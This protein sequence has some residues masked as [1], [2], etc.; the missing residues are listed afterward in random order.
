MNEFMASVRV[1]SSQE[2]A[3]T[4][5][6]PD[7]NALGIPTADQQRMAT[8]QRVQEWNA[9]MESMRANESSLALSQEATGTHNSTDRN[10]LGIPT[11]DRQRIATQQRVR[12]LNEFM[13]FVRTNESSR[14]PRQEPTGLPELTGRNTFHTPAS[15]HQDIERGFASRQRMQE[16]P[17][18][19]RFARTNE[20]SR[21][22]SQEPTGPSESTSGNTLDTPIGAGDRRDIAQGRANRQRVQELLDLTYL[23]RANDPSGM[24]NQQ[25]L[26]DAVDMLI[27]M[28]DTDLTDLV[29]RNGFYVIEHLRDIG[30]LPSY[31][32]AAP[33]Q[34][35]ARNAHNDPE[36]LVRNLLALV[37]ADPPLLP[38]RHRSSS[39]SADRP[40]E[41]GGTPAGPSGMPSQAVLTDAVGMLMGLHDVDLR[42]LAGSNALNVIEHLHDI[43]RLPSDRLAPRVR[44]AAR[45][46]RN[47]PQQLVLSLLALVTADSPL[48][49]ARP[50]STS[51]PVNRPAETGGTPAG[52][53]GMPSQ[54]VLT[55]AVGMLMGLHDVDLRDLA[56][57]NALNVIEHLH[58][59]QRLP[60]DRLAPRVRQAARDARN[61]PQQLV[62]SLL[63]L[64]TA[65]SPLLPARPR[66]TSSPVNRRAEAGGT[67]AGPSGMPSQ[68]V[69]TDAVGMLMGLHDVDL[70]DLAGS[71]ALN[72]IEHLHD[73]QRLPSGRLAPRV[74]QA[75]RDARNDPQQLV[76]SLLALVT[77]D[78]PLLPARPRSTSSPVNRRAEAGGTSAGPSGMPS[79]AVLTDAVG[80][81]MGLHDVDL[82]DLA[83][84][85]ALNV[86]EHLHDIQRLPSDRLAP[87]VRQAA[88]DARNDPQQLVRSLLALVTADSP[89]LPAR[90]RSTSSPVNRPAE[91]GG[92]SAG[93]LGMPSRELLNDVVGRLTILRDRVARRPD[94]PSEQLNMI[95]LVIEHL[96]SDQLAPFVQQAA[97]EANNDSHQLV[98]YLLRWVT[99]DPSLLLPAHRPAEAGGTSAGSS[100]MPSREVLT[101][102]VGMLMDL[103]E[104]DLRDLAG[105]NGLNVIEHLHDIQRLPSDRLAPSVR[106]AALDAH[107]DAEQ[108]VRNLLALVTADSPLLPARPRSSS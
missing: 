17:D 90:P 44:Q 43:Q 19:T 26:T 83:G 94:R 84:S 58:D 86:I 68:A 98:R 28:H 41:A 88:R 49:P 22:P 80:M 20:S 72:V 61:D 3:G 75:A 100:G 40:A 63:A 8:Q 101:D 39:P 77:A 56:G 35:A 12:E 85:N 57:S 104:V 73:I 65:D 6:P 50:R 106:Q 71:N 16:L 55:D 51:S 45:D 38:V 32:L 107:N 42:D 48:L 74:R 60:S 52:P 69:L 108:L 9:F 59:I 70:R 102:A 93:P 66:S 97:R 31:Q 79:Q 96:R 87:R 25:A 5:N 53:L 62:L 7:H 27:G 76:R 54:A 4:H 21:V 1:A 10:A 91:A 24:P 36:Q 82:R 23:A 2:S 89:L 105:P 99:E 18:R 46:A 47:D 30:V 78:S 37:T 95:G 67:L 13:A 11:D 33:V 103:H 64:V 81:L 15:D 92:T 29:G 34:Q 14:V